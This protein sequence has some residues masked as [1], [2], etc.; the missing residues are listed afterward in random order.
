MTPQNMF[1]HQIHGSSINSKVQCLISDALYLSLI[2][3]HISFCRSNSLLETS[4]I[5]LSLSFICSY[6]CYSVFLSRGD[7]KKEKNGGKME[8]ARIHPGTMK[9]SIFFLL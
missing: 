3:L 6:V 1:G 4:R 2:I 5:I 9:N 8:R 7:N